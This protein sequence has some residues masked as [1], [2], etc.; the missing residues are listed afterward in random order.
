MEQLPENF[1]SK[2]QQNDLRLLPLIIAAVAC[3]VIAVTS[4]YV[5]WLL[6]GTKS[7]YR[8]QPTTASTKPLPIVPPKSE[9]KPASQEEKLAAQPQVENAPAAN[10]LEKPTALAPAGELPIPASEVVMG[11]GDTKRPLQRQFVNDFAVAETEVT[12]AQFREFVEATESKIQVPKGKD[13]EP[14]TN[15]TWREAKAYCDWLSRKLGV[16]V[17]LPTEA[18]WELAARGADGL[19]YPWGNQWREEAVFTAETAGKVQPVKSFPLNKSPFGAFDMAGNVW[20]WTADASRNER[21]QNEKFT[22]E[23]AE[24]KDSILRV[25]KGGAAAEKKENISGQSRVSLPENARLPLVGFR[26]V[27]VRKK[28]DAAAKPEN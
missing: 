12:N 14:V 28:P 16:E 5:L 15:I 25:V 23:D 19:K 2:P 3:F 18:E 9:E 27:V 6:L 20:E 10:E 24:Y 4:G 13:D 8:N 11:G 26:Y 1:T 21:G 7:P 22:G 17:R